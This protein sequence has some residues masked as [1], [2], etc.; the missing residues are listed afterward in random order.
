VGSGMIWVGEGMPWVGSERRSLVR[1][2]DGYPKSRHGRYAPQS[3]N[4][5]ERYNYVFHAVP[6]LL[7]RCRTSLV[8]NKYPSETLIIRLA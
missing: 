7:Y 5:K 8:C 4:R 6:V 1:M 2:S 3:W